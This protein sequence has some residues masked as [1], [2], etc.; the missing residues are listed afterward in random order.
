MPK[1]NE[2]DDIIRSLQ[3]ELKAMRKAADAA[4]PVPF[5]E[6]RL[7]AKEARTRYRQMSK[8]QIAQLQPEQREDMLKLLGLQEVL[9]QLRSEG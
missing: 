6:E 9:N 5:G 3:G 1:R 2:F 7:S 8:E 4:K